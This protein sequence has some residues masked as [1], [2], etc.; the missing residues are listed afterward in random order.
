MN[1]VKVTDTQNRKLLGEGRNYG[2]G[3]AF[4]RPLDEALTEFETVQ[5]ITCCKDY[6]N[7]VVWAEANP[8]KSI[9]VFGLKYT[10]RGDVYRDGAAFII[11][12]ILPSNTGWKGYD[13]E[14][15]EKQLHDHIDYVKVLLNSLDESLKLTATDI[16]EVVGI[17]NAYMLK[18]DTRWC[19][20]TAS[21]S[22]F[23][24][25][26][27]MGQFYNGETPPRQFLETYKDSLDLPLWTPTKEK[28]F[29][30]LDTAYIPDSPT[31]LDQ[32][33]DRVHNSGLVAFCSKKTF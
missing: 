1:K 14:K 22:L 21:I 15:H 19:I 4:C 27:R 17:P 23:T 30:M 33:V 7:D 25:I 8:G 26:C 28:V 18:L 12:K 10:H 13:V 31:L 29:K 11:I 6:L 20:S 16:A 32:P 9:S 3:F 2:M 5:A 24:L